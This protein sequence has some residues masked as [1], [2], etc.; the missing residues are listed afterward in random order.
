VGRGVSRDSRDLDGD[1]VVAPSYETPFDDHEPFTVLRPEE[2]GRRLG[3]TARSARRAIGRGELKASRACGLRVLGEDAA[4][5]WTAKVVV[6]QL[7]KQREQAPASR[8]SFPLR[9][10]LGAG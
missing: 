8:R 4:G 9:D 3:V 2:I 6:T 1:Q 10:D 5:W 7:R